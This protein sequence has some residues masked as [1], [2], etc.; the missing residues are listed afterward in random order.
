M[1]SV[2]GSLEQEKLIGRDAKNGLDFLRRD[3][4]SPNA[5]NA[6]REEQ[7]QQKTQLKKQNKGYMQ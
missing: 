7:G 3:I 1:H 6:C 2:N 5:N 4:K